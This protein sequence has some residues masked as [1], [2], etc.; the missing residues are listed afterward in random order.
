[1]KIAV[2]GPSPVPYVYGGAEK[3]MF[4]LCASINKYTSHQC[5]L[6]KVPVDEFSFWA[7]IDSYYMFYKMDLSQFDMIISL[8]YPAWMVQHENSICWLIHTLRGLYD[9]YPSELP[10]TCKSGCEDIDEIIHFMEVDNNPDNLDA[11]FSKVYDL[12]KHNI[13][14]SY[15]D[16]PGPFIRLLLH[17]MDN[18]ALRKQKKLFTNSNTV[19]MRKEYFPQGIEVHSLYPPIEEKN[20]MCEGSDFF[21]VCSR[22]DEPKRFGT[23]VSSYKLCKTEKKL[24]IAGTGPFEEELRKKIAED[25]RIELLGFVSDEEK[26]RLY[27]NCIAVPFIPFQE[28]YGYITIE[29]MMHK[30]PVITMLDSGG[31]TEFVNDGINGFVV[32]SETQLATR[33]DFYAENSNIALIHGVNAYERVKNITWNRCVNMMLSE[34]DEYDDIYIYTSKTK[35]NKITVTSTFG[36]FPPLGGGQARIFNLYSHLQDYDVE[37]VSSTSHLEHKFN[38]IIASGVSE[39]RI[40]RTKIHDE[41]H[42]AI[43]E[44][45]GID[46]TDVAMIKLSGLSEDYGAQLK[47][48]MKDSDIVVASHPYM[49]NEIKKYLSSSQVLIYEA[50]NVEYL[51]KRKMLN[52]SIEAKELLEQLYN[53]EKELCEDAKVILTCLDKDA[54]TLS[55]LYGISRNKC[56]IVPNG[57]DIKK[58][59]YTSIQSRLHKK[60]VM[61]LKNKIGIFMGSWHAPNLEACEKIIE[62]SHECPNTYIFFLGSQCNY[63]KNRVLPAN[64]SLLGV[65]SE[66]EKNRIFSLADFALNPMISGSGTNLKMLDYMAA[67]I[68][69]IS[70]QFGTRGICDESCCIICSLDNFAECINEFELEKY[71]D[72]VN[73]A[74]SLAERKYDWQVIANNFQRNLYSLYC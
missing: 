52:D 2:V 29:A 11:F 13:P 55:E 47:V 35:K 69:V 4:E 44:K 26:E 54:I 66:E 61:G 1:M 19:K 30:K 10:R 56:I 24:L 43:A 12:K 15:Y 20:Y 37:I 3:H 63:F 57:V 48:S 40:P 74:R 25:S 41:C 49:Y 62:F 65:V 14:D 34:Y 5:E 42:A 50:H 60:R 59:K 71:D 17:Y 22:I 58:S 64:I 27:S 68:P 21:F 31:P 38:S 39:N 46:V 23:L 6:I 72:M 36:I 28:D 45:V 73:R 9:T 32:D 53:M 51:M 33:I 8:K 16:F 67:G 7:L 18:Y 70:T